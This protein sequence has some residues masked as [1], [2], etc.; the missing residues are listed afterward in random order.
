VLAART[1]GLVN[2]TGVPGKVLAGGRRVRGI[3]SRIGDQMVAHLNFFVANSPYPC[4]VALPRNEAQ[5]ILFSRVHALGVRVGYDRTL[6][7]LG[8][9][10]AGAREPGFCHLHTHLAAPMAAGR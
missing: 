5:R 2:L 7:A 9:G 4:S 3:E 10:A 6:T 8:Q 1:E